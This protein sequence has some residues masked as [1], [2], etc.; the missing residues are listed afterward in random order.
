MFKQFETPINKALGNN[1]VRIST[2]VSPKCF[3]ASYSSTMVKHS[4]S[5]KLVAFVSPTKV[6]RQGDSKS[7]RDA[8]KIQESC[9]FIRTRAFLHPS[10]ETKDD[11]AHGHDELSDP[12]P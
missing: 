8:K 4:I 1:A 11:L 9:K 2:F 12:H 3:G 7:I 10:L 5:R 6:F